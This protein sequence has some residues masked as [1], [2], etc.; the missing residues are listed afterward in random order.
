VIKLAAEID[1]LHRMPFF[2]L[3]FRHSGM[4]RSD[5][6]EIRFCA[7]DQTRNL[8]IP[9]RRF[10]P[11]GVTGVSHRLDA[12]LG[13]DVMPF[14]HFGCDALAQTVRAIGD[15]LKTVDAQLLDDIR[16]LQHFD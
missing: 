13:D 9:D 3:V 10:A 16:L 7:E 6:I 12:G 14:R 5:K 15:D 11:S 1:N 2:K 4:V 8:E